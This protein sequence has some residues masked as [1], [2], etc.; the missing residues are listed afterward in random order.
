MNAIKIFYAD[1]DDDDLLFF[2]DA[3]ELIAGDSDKMISLVTYKNGEKLI[4]NI[5]CNEEK[6]SVLFLD[7]N[8]PYKSGFQLLEEIRMQPD[9]DKFPVIMYSTSADEGN[10]VKSQ[11]L[12]ANYYV[13]KP[14]DFNDLI[15]MIKSFITIN[16]DNHIAD[17]NNFV[18]K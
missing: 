10:I 15:N 3:V 7:I 12:G 11:N 8:M 14:Y 9:L 5:K 1:D 4:E 16:W 6:N 18:Y 17:F 2:N 13:V